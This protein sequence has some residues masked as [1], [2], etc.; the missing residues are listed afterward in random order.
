MISFNDWLNEY[1]ASDLTVNIPK[2]PR[3]NSKISVDSEKF[4]IIPIK[5]NQDQHAVLKKYTENNPKFLQC[6][7]LLNR[8]ESDTVFSSNSELINLKELVEYIFNN[9]DD[10]SHVFIANQVMDMIQ[11]LEKELAAS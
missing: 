8:A 4:N 5:I 9:S 11:K 7:N 6:D 2:I 3:R 10:K 1:A